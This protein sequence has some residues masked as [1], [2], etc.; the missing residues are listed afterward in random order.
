[1]N[2]TVRHRL[3]PHTERAITDPGRVLLH[4]EHDH[5][6]KVHASA[7]TVGACKQHRVIYTRGDIDVLPAGMSAQWEEAER[8][9]AVLLRLPHALV[10]RA[11]EELGLSPEQVE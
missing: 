9:T 7:P 1:M 3:V 11:A 2:A 5:R 6:L 10:R 8:S 4:A